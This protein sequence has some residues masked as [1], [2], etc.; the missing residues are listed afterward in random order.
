MC[1]RDSAACLG[2]PCSPIRWGWF[3]RGPCQCKHIFH[4]STGH[5]LRRFP[6]GTA[7]ISETC[8]RVLVHGVYGRVNGCD[9]F[10]AQRH[11]FGF[12]TA[13]RG[14]HSPN[15]LELS[16]IRNTSVSSLPRTTFWL[17]TTRQP[18]RTTRTTRSGSEK[19]GLPQ[20]SGRTSG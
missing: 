17:Y 19:Q 11:G 12:S 18:R 9:M 4:T 14:Q 10:L 15:T 5:H 6:S 3:W 2:L 1:I 20:P 13:A 16:T 7:T 8:W